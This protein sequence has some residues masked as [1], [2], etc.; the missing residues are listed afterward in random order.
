MNKGRKNFSEPSSDQFLKLPEINQKKN[1]ILNNNDSKY[2]L[3][4]NNDS[5]LNSKYV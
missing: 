2:N 1:Y 4:K 5:N 3:N